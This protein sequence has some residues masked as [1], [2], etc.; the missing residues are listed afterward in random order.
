MK[1]DGYSKH[2]RLT[3][4]HT[5]T[6]A[7]TPLPPPPTLTHT[8]TIHTHTHTHAH[9]ICPGK[10]GFDRHTFYKT[11]DYNKNRKYE[12]E[13]LRTRIKNDRAARPSG[14]RHWY[15]RSKQINSSINKLILVINSGHFYSA[16]SHRLQ[17]WAHRPLLDQQSW[18]GVGVGGGGG[19]PAQDGHLDF[20]TAP[21][22]SPFHGALHPRKP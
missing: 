15:K 19:G 13:D 14:S 5:L 1:V 12:N 18:D 4:S 11:R 22:T 3:H 8:H 16:V 20:H 6:R 17:G 9:K 2:T 10:G 7:C 21:E